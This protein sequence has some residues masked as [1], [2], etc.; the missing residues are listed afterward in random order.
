MPP[1]TAA[2][3]AAAPQKEQASWRAGS[4]GWAWIFRVYGLGLGFM[5]V[6]GYP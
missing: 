6:Q 1:A 2:A 4:V 5:D 3:A